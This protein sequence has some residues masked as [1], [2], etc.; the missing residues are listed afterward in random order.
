MMTTTGETTMTH[1]LTPD[2][3]RRALEIKEKVSREA[4]AEMAKAKRWFRDDLER[5]K[6]KRDQGQD[7]PAST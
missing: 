7:R 1:S 5:R 6:A 2:E 4:D 3:E